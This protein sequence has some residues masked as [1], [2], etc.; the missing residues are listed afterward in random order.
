S[1]ITLNRGIASQLSGVID[2][3]HR[4]GNSATTLFLTTSFASY[5]SEWSQKY[6]P[7]P[8]SVDLYA[9][10]SH[11]LRTILT[12]SNMITS[13]S[14]PLSCNGC[15]GYVSL[16]T[17]LNNVGSDSTIGIASMITDDNQVVVPT[18][19]TVKNTVAASPSNRNST[20][21]TLS[22]L[23]DLK[24][25]S[26]FNIKGVQTYPLCT[27]TYWS[28]LN[29]Q[30]D[31]TA[32]VAILDYIQFGLT[33]VRQMNVDTL[34]SAP[35]PKI[36]D[37]ISRNLISSNVICNNNIKCSEY[38]DTVLPGLVYVFGGLAILGACI[39]VAII[40][41]VVS[42]LIHRGL[43]RPSNDYVN[44]KDS[45]LKSVLIT[46]DSLATIKMN[47]KDGND[48]SSDEI[49]LEKQIGSGSFSEVYKGTWLGAVVAIKRFLLNETS[50]HEVLEDFMKETTLMSGMRHPNVVL[51]LGATVKEPH[52]YIVTE[53]CERG[54][55]QHIIR[56]KKQ[57]LSAKKTTRLA[58]DAARGMLYL[59]RSDPPILHRDFKS[60]NLLVSKDWTVKVADFGMS[61]VLDPNA[62]MTVCGTAETCSPE[63]LSRNQYTEKAD[64]YSFGI[65][66]WEMYTREVL[67]P[68]LNFYELSSRV[69]NEG[70]RPPTDG[71]KFKSGKIP[72]KIKDLMERC[73]HFDPKVRYSFEEIVVILEDVLTS[74]EATFTNSPTYYKND[75]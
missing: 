19:Q 21:Q 74:L 20:Y 41:I 68:S 4:T 58:L 70:L 35:T 53:F 57:K 11:R 72:T 48:L 51:Y 32:G 62:C 7:K 67:Y 40:I 29:V 55:I 17:Y 36:L 47:T 64:V 25:L 69:V 12:T 8:N 50:S 61:R 10:P 37:Q 2:P 26:L 52:L 16:D 6:T 65:V 63:V 42:C 28:V 30:T 60:A 56:D 31:S 5:S 46:S 44:I 59:H 18:L 38:K 24:M 22:S 1:I 66:L 3:L 73:W 43:K 49:V 71:E 39:L 75:V 13:V 45:S 9:L 27:Y 34:G 54:N 15:I 33:Y 14:S 23:P